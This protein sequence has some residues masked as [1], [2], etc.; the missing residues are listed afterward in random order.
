MFYVNSSFYYDSCREFLTNLI[1]NFWLLYL[2]FQ[3]FL[4]SNHIQLNEEFM[5]KHIIFPG[6]KGLDNLFDESNNGCL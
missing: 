3:N 2:E 5:S 4:D 1:Q 6:L